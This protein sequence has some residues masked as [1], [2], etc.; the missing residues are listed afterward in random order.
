MQGVECNFFVYDVS[1]GAKVLMSIILLKSKLLLCATTLQV[2]NFNIEDFIAITVTQGRMTRPVYH[3]EQ[4]D[5]MTKS[6]LTI[7]FIENLK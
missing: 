2:Q 5:R 4:N 6:K 7:T 3:N 1:I